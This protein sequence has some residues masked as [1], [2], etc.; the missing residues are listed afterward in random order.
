MTPTRMRTMAAVMISFVCLS[1]DHSF[2]AGGEEFHLVTPEE[3]AREQAEG[4]ARESPD[5]STP[6]AP[7]IEVVEPKD[8]SHIVVPVNINIRFIPQENGKI[9]INTLRILYGWLELD[10]TNRVRKYCEVTASGIRAD[11]ARLPPGS[12]RLTVKVADTNGRVGST[13]VFYRVVQ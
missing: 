3:H 13:E 4:Q 7:L 2:A 10:I 5:V 12:H 11:K 6:G 8:L 9:D 1:I